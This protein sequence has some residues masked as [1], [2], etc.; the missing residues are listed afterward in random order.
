MQRKVKRILFA[1][2]I[3]ALNVQANEI[4]SIFSVT[5]TQHQEGTS[6]CR[7]VYCDPTPCDDGNIIS[8]QEDARQVA[9]SV[10]S[11]NVSARLSEWQ[12]PQLGQASANFI[13]ILRN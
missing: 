7:H 4:G 11:P 3:I 1:T 5:G 9:N 13:C 6:C 8:G 10:C 12:Y 2:I